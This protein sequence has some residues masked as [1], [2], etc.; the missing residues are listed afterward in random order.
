MQVH[1]KSRQDRERKRAQSIAYDES[2]FG[3]SVFTLRPAGL[4]L[5]KR[6]CEGDCRLNAFSSLD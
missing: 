1:A 2:F 4:A 6:L 5:P 3:V